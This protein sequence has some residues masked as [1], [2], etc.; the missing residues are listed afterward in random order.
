MI[1]DSKNTYFTIIDKQ[2]IR[3]ATPFSTCS[4]ITDLSKSSANLSS[5]STFLLIGPGCK[6]RASG[7]ANFNFS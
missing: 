3:T 7:F 6:T 1:D 2:A 4:L 5:I